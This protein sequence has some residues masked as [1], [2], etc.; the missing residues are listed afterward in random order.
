MSP[1]TAYTP[2]RRYAYAAFSLLA[3]IWLWVFLGRPGTVGGVA[4]AAAEVKDK[5]AEKVA[6]KI[7]SSE[8]GGN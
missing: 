7:G 6:E 5:V 4:S 1:P 3:L 8:K 2:N